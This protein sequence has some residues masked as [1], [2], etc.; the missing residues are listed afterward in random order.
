MKKL[1]ALISPEGKTKEQLIN[2]THQAMQKYFRVEKEVLSQD[3]L[4][5]DKAEEEQGTG[6]KPRQKNKQVCLRTMMLQG[7]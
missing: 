1:I 5:E 4:I 2:E 6:Y 3:N 7:Q